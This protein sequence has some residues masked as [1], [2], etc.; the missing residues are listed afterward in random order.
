MWLKLVSIAIIQPPDL[1][2]VI[3]HKA[4]RFLIRLH[5]SFVG[6]LVA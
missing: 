3:F 2:R 4:K 5:A 6:G 1:S